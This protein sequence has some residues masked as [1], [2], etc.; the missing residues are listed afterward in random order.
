MPP[1]KA[2]PPTKPKSAAERW[3]A[4]LKEEYYNDA[5]FASNLVC[6]WSHLTCQGG[7]APDG[8]RA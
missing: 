6:S 2:L 1:A 7:P 8:T 5:K 4:W 3:Q